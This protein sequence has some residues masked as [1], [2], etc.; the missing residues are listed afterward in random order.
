MALDE[1]DDPVVFLAKDTLSKGKQA[2]VFVNTKR[3]AEKSAET[4]S[5]ALHSSDKTLEKLSE[6]I[7]KAVSSPTKQCR[8]LAKCVKKGVAFHHA[9]LTQKQKDI[10]EDAFR[11][12][13]IKIISCTPTLAAGVDMPAFRTIIRD[14]KRYS[15]GKNR[16][17]PVLEYMQMAGR[18]GRP[19]FDSVGE[20]III[21][22][23]DK[24]KDKLHEMYILGEPEEI[25]SK[26]AVEPVLRT[27]LLSLISSGFVSSEEDL[28]NFFEETFWAHQFM[29]TARLHQIIDKMLFLLEEWAFITKADNNTRKSSGDF[30]SANMLLDPQTTYFPTSLGKRVAELYLDPLTA[31]NLAEGLSKA[32]SSGMSDFSLIHLICCSLEMRPFLR[33]KNKEI[34]EIESLIAEKEDEL[35][36]EPSELLSELYSAKTFMDTIKTALMLNDWI[37]EKDEEYLLERYDIRPGE[38]RAKVEVSIWLLYSAYEL[39][40]I[41]GLNSLRSKIIKIRSRMKYGSK[42]ELLPL[43]RMKGIGRV[44]AR[45]LFKNNIKDAGDLKN[46]DITTLVQLLGKSTAIK[47]KEQ[48]GEKVDKLKVPEKRRKGQISLKDFY[49]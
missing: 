3:S 15:L 16:Y 34:E 20:S 36:A 45:R 17:I 11:N 21:A 19:K 14:L 12:S 9:G 26:L 25:Y 30:V 35:I 41:L 44:R 47:L 24:E 23:T 4:I 7:L 48:V 49:S 39:A 29:D 46:I 2:L 5:K 33:V 38:I 43:L 28:L 31:K 8:R 40:R 18:A 10:I 32:E 22:S 37:N 27:Y 42:E 6:S 13:I 1:H